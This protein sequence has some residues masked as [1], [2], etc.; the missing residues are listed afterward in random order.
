MREI[1][2]FFCEMTIIIKVKE[3]AWQFHLGLITNHFLFYADY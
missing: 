1:V 3:A 2:S